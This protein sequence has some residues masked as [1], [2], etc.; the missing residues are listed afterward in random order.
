MTMNQNSLGYSGNDSAEIGL[1]PSIQKLIAPDAKGSVELKFDG[2]GTLHLMER[3]GDGKLVSDSYLKKDDDFDGMKPTREFTNTDRL[4]RLMRTN[5]RLGIAVKIRNVLI[6][7]GAVV[8]V[9]FCMLLRL[10]LQRYM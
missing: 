8:F 9:L 1:D 5:A 7:V 4:E 3:T 2:Y 6:A 10:T